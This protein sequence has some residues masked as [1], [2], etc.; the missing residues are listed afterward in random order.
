MRQTIGLGTGKGRTQPAGLS[1]KGSPKSNAGPAHPILSL[2]R[3]VGNRAV[4][5]L[6]APTPVQRDDDGWLGSI[7]SALSDAGSAVVSGVGSAIDTGA[8]LAS[9]AGSGIASG[10]RTAA[11]DVSDVAGGTEGDVEYQRS[12]VCDDGELLHAGAGDDS[13]PAAPARLRQGLVSLDPKTG[14]VT[15]LLLVS[16]AAGL[17]GQCDDAGRAGQS[18]ADLVSLLS[19]RFRALARGAGRKISDAG[20]ERVAVG[21]SLDTSRV[22]RCGISIPSADARAGCDPGGVWSSPRQ[23]RLG[24][25]GGVA[26]RGPRE[27]REGAKPPMS[28]GAGR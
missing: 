6:L 21:N 4:Q 8:D 7:G 20:V 10:A 2:Q 9:S 19:H 24:A 15:F 22:A 13:W 26:E 5:S 25:P 11:S 27:A 16:R 12:G 1:P 17:V 14:Q 23:G 3:S 28:T 18:R